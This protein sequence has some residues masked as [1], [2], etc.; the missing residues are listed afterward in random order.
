MLEELKETPTRRT[1]KR[2]ANSLDEHSLDRAQ[3]LTAMR[4]LDVPKG[5]RPSASFLSL[6]DDCIISNITNLGVL[7]GVSESQS[8]CVTR[9]I[10]EL[11]HG[12]LASSPAK[13]SKVK[14]DLSKDLDALEDT[15]NDGFDQL[16]IKEMNSA[17]LEDF[18][19]ENNSH[20]GDICPLKSRKN[21]YPVKSNMFRK[22]KIG[23]KTT[24]KT[25]GLK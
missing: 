18:L 15:E 16:M 5:T 24:K 14:R 19:T 7:M 6:T 11:E 12:R 10:R 1:S 17:A 9:H 23:T 4:N 2:R 25:K 3:R 21:L 20:L 22:K 8:K 13:Q